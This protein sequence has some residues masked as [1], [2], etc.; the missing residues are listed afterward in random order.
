M[1]NNMTKRIKPNLYFLVLI[2]LLFACQARELEQNSMVI[3][4][5][6]TS[7]EINV[8][9][10]E[11]IIS[12][13]TLST[14]P[15]ANN[16][17]LPTEELSSTPTPEHSWIA[18]TPQSPEP[19]ST[20]RA[21]VKDLLETNM[22]CKLPCWWG[23]VPGKTKFSDAIKMLSPLAENIWIK[24]MDSEG[25]LDAD[26]S[27]PDPEEVNVYSLR[28]YIVAVNDIIQQMELTLGNINQYAFSK[29]IHDYGEPQ[30]VW[31]EGFLDPSN[32][33]PFWIFICYPYKGIINV[34]DLSAE[35]I[36]EM[37]RLCPGP[38]PPTTVILW[39]PVDDINF[40]SMAGKTTSL[41]F[42]T[43]E[44]RFLVPLRQATDLTLLEIS[45]RGCFDTPKDLWVVR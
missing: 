32:N 36:G 12:T 21:M 4:K 38:I 1:R 13:I 42:L 40:L 26:I 30:E 6:P 22:G 29:L 11:Q 20:S 3:S 31:I 19:I 2:F 44:K 34:F 35:D 23:I 10:T 43:K 5:V 24:E 17:I 37:M 14:T 15:T 41:Q 33:N 27:F 28:L 8:T 9:K 16:D 45:Q 39:D 7:P 25:S 18:L